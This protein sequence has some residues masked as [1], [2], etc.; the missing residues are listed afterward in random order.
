M[1]TT[2]EPA[3][4]LPFLGMVTN[5]DRFLTTLEKDQTFKYSSA[6]TFS[7]IKRIAANRGIEV[8]KVVNKRLIKVIKNKITDPQMFHFDEKYIDA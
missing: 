1:V 3:E 7:Y 6:Y 5:I 2:T 8:E 4:K